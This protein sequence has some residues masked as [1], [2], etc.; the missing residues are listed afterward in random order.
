MST[1]LPKDATPEGWDA[2]ADAYDQAITR[3]TRQY[4]EEAVKLAGIRPGHEVLDVAA[5][6]GAATFAAV[7]AGATVTATDFSPEMIRRLRENLRRQGLDHVTAEVMDGQALDLPEDRFDAAVSLF[8]VIFFPDRAAGF[9][10]LHRVLKPGGRAV[11]AGW[12]TPDKVGMVSIFGDAARAAI[13]DLPRP[14]EPPPIYSLQDPERFRAELEAA[15]FRDVRIVPVV[16]TW[17]PGTPEEFWERWSGA[18]PV[19]ETLWEAYPDRRTA[20]RDE[21]LRLARER[22][23]EDVR[24]D[25]EALMGV[26]T[27]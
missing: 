27:K 26:G 24:I 23:G 18:S 13:P 5:G 10:E 1:I 3:F 16:K 9:R 2:A 8:G 25:A 21:F 7:A 17:T 19:F 22:H 11:V 12:S 15:G 20:I 4:A 6:P 14:A